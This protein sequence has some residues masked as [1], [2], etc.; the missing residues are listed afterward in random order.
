MEKIK[1]GYKVKIIVIAVALSFILNAIT[2]ADGM[3]QLP[4]KTCL[5]KPSGFIDQQEIQRYQVV[6]VVEWMRGLIEKVK[7]STQKEERR[8]QTHRPPISH[9]LATN[10]R[11]LFKILKPSN[12]APAGVSDRKIAKKSETRPVNGGFVMDRRDFLKTATAATGALSEGAIPVVRAI[13]AR[14][15]ETVVVPGDVLLE[16]AIS[17]LS[18]VRHSSLLEIIQLGDKIKSYKVNKRQNSRPIGLWVYEFLTNRINNPSI[19]IIGALPG[20]EELETLQAFFRGGWSD[21][22]PTEKRMAVI[23]LRI[24]ELEKNHTGNKAEIDSL[25]REEDILIEKAGRNREANKRKLSSHPVAQ[26]FMDRDR[27][28]YYWQR[29]TPNV[30]QFF[31]ELSDICAYLR[32]PVKGPID[33][34]AKDSDTTHLANILNNFLSRGVEV[35][36]DDPWFKAFRYWQARYEQI[37][38]ALLEEFVE[39]EDGTYGWEKSYPGESTTI[40]D[41]IKEL[42]TPTRPWELTQQK[43]QEEDRLREA[44]QEQKQARAKAVVLYNPPLK[45]LSTLIENRLQHGP[46]TLEISWNYL[47]MQPI[48]YLIWGKDA[49]REMLALPGR[50]E[51]ALKSLFLNNGNLPLAGSR[52]EL[53]FNSGDKVF[54]KLTFQNLKAH[55]NPQPFENPLIKMHNYNNSL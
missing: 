36:T 55:T 44:E 24:G 3:K 47:G 39:F 26:A 27:N 12:G 11:E 32:D 31:S 21:E 29:E 35:I 9:R 38:A 45:A 51:I 41:R 40:Y 4:V 2:L 17:I 20:Q 1:K 28:R 50:Y 5:R 49:K 16:T 33:T 54:E 42:K 30:D 13:V 22:S 46:V 48:A 8:Q 34:L 53:T 25:F 19:D 52:T 37:R 43:W 18:P 6:T 15:P 10:R 7:R 23:N 14:L